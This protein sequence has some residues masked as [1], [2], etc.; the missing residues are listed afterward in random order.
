MG[1]PETNIF[2]ALKAVW[3]V[4]L[5]RNT[6]VLALTVPAPGVKISESAAKKRLAL[7]NAIKDYKRTNL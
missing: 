6:K 2:D 1:F 4:P 5:R 3:D 7:N